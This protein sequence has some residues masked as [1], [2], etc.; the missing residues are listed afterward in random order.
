MFPDGDTVPSV[1]FGHMEVRGI[2]GD[3]AKRFIVEIEAVG[4][5]GDETSHGGGR[6]GGGLVLEMAV[7]LCM[8]GGGGGGGGDGGGEE[9]EEGGEG[10]E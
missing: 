2:K 7:G 6:G 5:A 10:G 3:K 8:G 4:F 9:E 1:V